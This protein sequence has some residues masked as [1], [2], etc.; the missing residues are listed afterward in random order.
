MA[1][2]RLFS[3]LSD[4]EQL[5]F[6]M[7][8]ILEHSDYSTALSGYG[9]RL[10]E[11]LD[12]LE[13]KCGHLTPELALS[14]IRNKKQF[15]VVAVKYHPWPIWLENLARGL[16]AGHLKFGGGQY[17]NPKWAKEIDLLGV[18]EELTGRIGFDEMLV[19]Q[20]IADHLN[21]EG[22]DTQ[23]KYNST[24]KG[25]ETVRQH[26]MRMRNALNMDE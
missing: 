22:R 14:V 10:K 16:I 24:T 2:D 21:V 1:E 25:A 17:R 12:A 4:R 6:M 23:D 9:S 15:D 11:R 5:D 8:G 7:P 20:S 26:I 13:S 19:Y 18:F 3:D